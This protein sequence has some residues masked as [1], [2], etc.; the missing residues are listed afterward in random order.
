MKNIKL[1]KLVNTE[2]ATLQSEIS[3]EST[4][5]KHGKTHSQAHMIKARHTLSSLHSDVTRPFHKVSQVSLDELG[6]SRLSLG[7]ESV[8]HLLDGDGL[9]SGLLALLHAGGL[10]GGGLSRCSCGCFRFRLKKLKQVR[11]VR[12]D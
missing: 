10:R 2:A 5:R 6:V 1:H 12:T 3:R 8:S 9:E 7:H 11:M 4:N